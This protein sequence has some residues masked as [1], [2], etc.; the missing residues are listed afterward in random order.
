MPHTLTDHEPLTDILAD[1][2][3]ALMLHPLLPHDNLARLLEG[4]DRIEARLQDENMGEVFYYE[5]STQSRQIFYGQTSTGV[6][7]GEM[8]R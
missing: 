8:P 6:L 7:E 3:A 2:E 4:L 1:I 5:N